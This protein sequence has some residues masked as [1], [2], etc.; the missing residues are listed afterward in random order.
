MSRE[1]RRFYDFGAFHL[2]TLNRRLTRGD[3]AE[4]IPLTPKEFEVLLVLVENAGN[5]VAKN[6][7]LD[8]VWKD[9]FVGEET[10][11][12]NVLWL[13]KNSARETERAKN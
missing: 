7:L 6:A 9:A 12:R 5:V 1:T 10:L 3:V 2:D 13:R 11:M 4:T 8:V